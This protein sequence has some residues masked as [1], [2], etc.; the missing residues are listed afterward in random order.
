M[1]NILFSIVA[2]IAI[3]TMP[4][5]KTKKAEDLTP[6]AGNV[7]I[8]F[9]NLANNN[10]LNLGDAPNHTNSLGQKFSFNIFK[11]YISQIRLTDDKGVKT[12]LNNFT[13]IDE[14]ITNPKREVSYLNLPAGNYTNIT[15]NFG[16]DKAVNAAPTGEGDL[17]HNLGMW[18]GTEKY[19]FLKHEG[20]FIDAMNVKQSLLFHVGS[21]DAYVSDISLPIV[22][23][24]VNA[25]T[26]TIVVNFNTEKMYDGIDFN[27]QNNMM[28]AKG[29]DDE[30]VG[31]INTN[32]KTAFAF[33]KIQ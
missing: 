1:K 32:I 24:T 27:V 25:N 3:S 8:L 33:N 2:I 18:W 15:F 6:K 30:I 22:G 11:Y 17:G 28:S 26:K 5:C 29:A 10:A 4:S 14:D 9:N 31:K 20:N 13:L 12:N 7:K 16:L 23:L 19:L 21:D